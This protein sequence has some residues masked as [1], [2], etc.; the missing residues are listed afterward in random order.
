MLDAA[1]EYSYGITLAYAY[2]YI[3]FSFFFKITAEP[4]KDLFLYAIVFSAMGQIKF[5]YEY[6]FT[7]PLEIN[8]IFFSPIMIIGSVLIVSKFISKDVKAKEPTVEIYL[9]EFLA[10]KAPSAQNIALLTIGFIITMA[11][12]YATVETYHYIIRPALRSIYV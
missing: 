4:L 8:L 10:Y 12:Y 5:H 3:V 9:E 1:I 2:L 11:L 6:N 7:A